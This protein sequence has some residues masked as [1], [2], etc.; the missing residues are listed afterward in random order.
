[1]IDGVVLVNKPIGITSFAA[2]KKV[3]KQLQAKKVGHCGT[4]DPFAS[5]L[6]IVTIN[7]ATKI[8]RFIESQNKE[9]IATL[10]LGVKTDSG[11][12]TGKVIKRLKPPKF[13]VLQLNDVIKSFI[14]KQTQ[15]PPMHSAIKVNGQ[16]LYELARKGKTIDRE[17]RPIEIYDIK[18]IKY[19]GNTLTFKVNCT[20]GTYIRTLAEDLAKRLGCVGHLKNLERTAIGDFLLTD[21]KNI[22]KLSAAE[23]IIPIAQA[24]KS[25]SKYIVSRD[26]LSLVNNGG[27][28]VIDQDEEYVLVINQESTPLA[29][30]QKDGEVYRCLRGL[31]I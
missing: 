9:Y 6:L 13:E 28:L 8:A 12:N 23:D 11:D 3:S 10:V 20:K 16:K 31:T 18:L 5:G 21:A 24:L 14:G 1:M 22:D 29:I 17:P 4:L 30:Y 2:V 7:N 27:A 25:M 15:I 19:R 26:E